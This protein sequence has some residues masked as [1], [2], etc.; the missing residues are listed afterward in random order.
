MWIRYRFFNGS[1]H[2]SASGIVAA[3]P[4]PRLVNI[5]PKLFRSS[6]SSL[7][8]KLVLVPNVRERLQPLSGLHLF[9]RIAPAVGK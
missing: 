1:T 9:R 5:G 3:R 2:L 4:E 8:D 7:M 6:K